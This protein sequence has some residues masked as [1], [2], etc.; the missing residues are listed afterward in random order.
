MSCQT[1][2]KGRAFYGFAFQ[3]DHR[4]TPRTLQWRPGQAVTDG[5]LEMTIPETCSSR[6]LTF[7][8][9]LY[10]GKGRVALAGG[11]GALGLGQLVVPRV[12]GRITELRFEAVEDGELVRLNPRR[13]LAEANTSRRILH[14]PGLATDG[15]VVVKRIGPVFELVPVP[16]SATVTV[17]LPGRFGSVI[18]VSEDGKEADL[19][20][21][22][23]R[24][25]L[26][27]FRIGGAGAACRWRALPEGAR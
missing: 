8:V 24:D 23:F 12:A 13:Y 21:A 4:P 1:N 16:L 27:W 11:Q 5:P 20:A 15:A 2:A 14:F 6:T 19:A 7:S 9:G 25:G 3:S 22:E 18:G 17:G 10:D 26:S